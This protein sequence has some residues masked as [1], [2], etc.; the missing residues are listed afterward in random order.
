MLHEKLETAQRQ[1]RQA[2]VRLTLITLGCAAAI[3]LFL[4]GIV[5]IDFSRLGLGS[6]EVETAVEEA[7]P[8]A[9]PYQTE[10]PR[11]KPLQQERSQTDRSKPGTAARPQA[12]ADP[13]APPN[14]AAP[15][16]DPVEERAQAAARAQ[17]KEDLALFEAELLPEISQDTFGQWNRERQLEI[18]ERRDRAIS[19]FSQSAYEPALAGIADATRIARQEIAARGTAFDQA[20]SRA[21]SAYD[22]DDYE[23]AL[24]HISDALR[25]KP[26]SPEAQETKQAIDELPPLLALFEKA[27]VA[28]TENNLE[29][30][31]RYLRE[32]LKLAP[33]RS[34]LASR[35]EAVSTKIKDRDFAKHID[36]GMAAIARRDLSA[37]YKSLKNARDI[38]RGRP[39]AKFLSAEAA[40][41]ARE[42]QFQDI[43]RD[44]RSASDADNWKTA[45]GL[46]Q[47]ARDLYPDNAEAVEGVYRS[48][49]ITDLNAKFAKHL[50]APQRLASPNVAKVVQGLVSQA[51]PLT[52]HSPSLRNNAVELSGLVKAYGVKIQVRVVS[53]GET[54]ITVQGVGRVGKTQSKTIQLKPGHHTFE[55]IREGYRAKLIKVQIPPGA[56][57]FTVEIFCD[58]RI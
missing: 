5:T 56:E 17:F 35:L 25:L 23:T 38:Y 43:M 42:L 28:R 18:L 19:D 34:A 39:E 36:A 13:K 12:G 1:A 15:Q 58:E 48:K 33:T 51:A 2:R 27:A 40:T 29:A 7:P 22:L 4:F 6:S 10:R 16:I 9:R 21:Q 54:N 11:E 14:Q 49:N 53:D 3:A 50:Q 8:S 52:P 47:Q 24:F 30:E 20:L 57:G 44:A 55:G 31:E 41:L 26:E 32:A 37:A 46:Y 45:G